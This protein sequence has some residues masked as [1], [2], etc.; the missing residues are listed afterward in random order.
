MGKKMKERRVYTKEFKTEA[1]ALAEKRE[2]PVT[3]TARDP[4]VNENVLYR[5]MQR[6]KAAVHDRLP[7][8]PGHGRPRGEELVRLRKEVKALRTADEILKKAAG[9]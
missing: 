2:K 9:L 7:A 6:S 5:W 3:Q 4:G 1:V 8:L